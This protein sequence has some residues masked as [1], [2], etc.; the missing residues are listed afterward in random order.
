[1]LPDG[2]FWNEGRIIDL[3]SSFLQS[4]MFTSAYTTSL[5]HATLAIFMRQTFNMQVETPAS[6]AHSALKDCHDKQPSSTA[7]GSWF[8]TARS[9]LTSMAKASR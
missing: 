4:C 8:R 6:P 2:S 7:K 9:R 5:G 1:M 3:R